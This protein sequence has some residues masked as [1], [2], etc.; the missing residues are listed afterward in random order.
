MKIL[1]TVKLETE[2][3]TLRKFTMNDLQGLFDWASNENVTTYMKWNAYKSEDEVEKDI[4]KWI[5]QYEENSIH[6]CVELKESNVQIGRINVVVHR[7]NHYCEVGFC[8]GEKFWNCGYATEALEAV[9]QFLLKECDFHVVE[10]KCERENKACER[11]L[12]KAGMIK[13]AELRQRSYN[14]KKECYDDLLCYYA[15]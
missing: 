14:Y 8:F 15:M 11:V 1:G 7:N 2:R 9:L 5:S 12:I 3:L 4:S 10:A 6:W 13:E